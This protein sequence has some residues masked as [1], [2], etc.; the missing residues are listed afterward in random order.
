MYI[1]GTIAEINDLLNGLPEDVSR[2][3]GMPEETRA[4]ATL[5]K[6]AKLSEETSIR[7][8]DF[9]LTI[10][11]KKNSLEDIPRFLRDSLGVSD[12]A[13]LKLFLGH[14]AERLSWYGDYFPNLSE[15][16]GKWGV[17]FRNGEPL[18]TTVRRD[19]ATEAAARNRESVTAA[20]RSIEKIS[21]LP[22]LGKYPKLGEQIVTRERLQLK[23]QPEPVRPNLTNWLRVYRDEL[24]VGYHDPMTRGKFI[25]DSVNCKKLSSEER[26]RL[27]LV[28]R[29]IEENM[30]IDIDPT[31]M[32][33]V[34]PE[35]RASEK[36]HP[37]SRSTA[38]A[39]PLP[40]VVLPKVVSQ[41]AWP[42]QRP[43]APNPVT[44]PVRSPGPSAVSNDADVRSERP[45][46]RPFVPTPPVLQSPPPAPA[47]RPVSFVPSPPPDLPVGG[48]FSFSSSH[49]LPVE[50]E[51]DGGL[52]IRRPDV[53]PLPSGQAAFDQRV[54]D[55]VE[56]VPS[57]LSRDG[58]NNAIQP[59]APDM[60]PF[61]IHPVGTRG[62][63]T[64]FGFG[65]GRTVNLRGD[66]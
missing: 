50:S 34:F 44:G 6:N 55:K 32:E 28:L 7:V 10:I 60:N 37:V 15:I 39:T 42:I 41:V 25:F 26:E 38:P 63:S 65:T 27:N 56:A 29:S 30:P 9:Y 11:A 3:L 53:A 23:S 20:S 59:T 54:A 4:N 43:S 61:H 62:E 22:A 16:A 45:Q 47:R 5:Q 12:P 40:A 58:K 24:G 46:P 14:F 17:A 49:A 57:E 13:V 31:K 18:I 66:K 35:F 33:I 2:V 64:D 51:E 19:L 1:P 48:S 36:S 8:N 52:S 21:L